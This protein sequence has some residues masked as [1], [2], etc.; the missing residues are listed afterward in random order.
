MRSLMLVVA[1]AVS[2]SGCAA[3]AGGL[4]GTL[5]HVDSW[6]DEF[7]SRTTYRMRNNVVPGDFGSA[8]ISIDAG[9]IDSPELGA[10]FTVFATY[11]SSE[12]IF[13]NSGESLSLLLDGELLRLTAPTNPRRDV[14]DGGRVREIATYLVS[15]DILR[16]IATATEVKMKLSGSRYYV[17]RTLT[18]ENIQRLR[19]F[20]AEYVDKD[21][22]AAPQT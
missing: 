3:K 4:F 11:Q 19:G 6:H 13:I 1:M 17:E 2:L 12:W 10:V 16:Q 7:E 21:P 18:P 22:T 8:R 15:A 5:Y 20:I 14:L 9:R